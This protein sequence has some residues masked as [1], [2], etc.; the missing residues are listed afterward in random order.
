MD[1]LHAR[2]QYSI[3]ANGFAEFGI[4]IRATLAREVSPLCE[5]L[6]E[7]KLG[8]TTTVVV[9]VY[10][11]SIHGYAVVPGPNI[12]VALYVAPLITI[13]VVSPLVTGIP[14]K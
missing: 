14:L 2:L 8:K 9:I 6:S 13:C 11:C 5:T 10:T 3:L 7:F 1:I 12:E 4:V